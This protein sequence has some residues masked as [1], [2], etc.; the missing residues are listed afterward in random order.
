MQKCFPCSMS[1]MGIMVI[2][3]ITQCMLGFIR[4]RREK[5]Q[6]QMFVIDEIEYEWS[7]TMP[8]TEQQLANQLPNF[9]CILFVFVW[10][11]DYMSTWSYLGNRCKAFSRLK[12]ECV[13]VFTNKG[14]KRIHIEE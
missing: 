8:I 7:F 13:K 4:V 9:V 12:G 2:Y 10:F 3:I 1:K 5:T 11:V 6:I 14:I